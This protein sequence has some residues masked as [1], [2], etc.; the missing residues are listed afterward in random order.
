MRVTQ[1]HDEGVRLVLQGLHESGLELLLGGAASGSA[2]CDPTGDH[3]VL[4]AHR[5]LLVGWWAW[6]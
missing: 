4:T 1:I 6:A 3:D 5:S 2:F